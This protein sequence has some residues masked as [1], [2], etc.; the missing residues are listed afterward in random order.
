MR[1]RRYLEDDG[2]SFKKNGGD[3]ETRTRDLCRDSFD[4]SSGVGGHL[5]ILYGTVRHFLSSPYCTQILLNQRISQTP[6]PA[7]FGMADD[8]SRTSL[9]LPTSR[10]GMFPSARLVLN[11]RRCQQ[12][13]VGELG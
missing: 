12:R 7:N 8:W 9:W 5:L 6:F 10:F 13:R 1:R 3:D 4:V 2:T 11:A